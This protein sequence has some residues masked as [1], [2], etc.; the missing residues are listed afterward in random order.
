VDVPVLFVPKSSSRLV[1]MQES[2]INIT[3][4]DD[5]QY[6]KYDKCVTLKLPDE[7]STLLHSN[8][9]NVS[10]KDGILHIG[11]HSFPIMTAPEAQTVDV[12]VPRGDGGRAAIIG[13][14]SEKWTI[15]QELQEGKMQEIRQSSL[16]AER[17]RKERQTMTLEMTPTMTRFKGRTNLNMDESVSLALMMHEEGKSDVSAKVSTL[18]AQGPMSMKELLSKIHR[19]SA[20]I[21]DALAQVAVHDATTNTYSLKVT[22]LHPSDDQ[23]REKY[24]R[25]CA[26]F[27][28]KYAQ[29]IKVDD[30]LRQWSAKTKTLMDAG[31]HKELSRLSV[32]EFTRQDAIHARLTRELTIIKGNIIQLANPIQATAATTKGKQVSRK[33]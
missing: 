16:A 5:V 12:A 19:K 20:L 22:K 4:S 33:E 26:L 9:Q 11:S 31:D 28:D 25:L 2:T 18:L 10:I 7:V 6:S 1:L 21:E 27:K 13:K 8:P 3:S 14:V 29:Y 32:E 30:V 15:R 24:D 23:R 17:E